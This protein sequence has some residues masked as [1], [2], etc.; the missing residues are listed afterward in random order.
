[1]LTGN[2]SSIQ[3]LRQHL[4][5]LDVPARRVIAKAYWATGKVGLD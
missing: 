2:A 3:Q 1:V 5:K 4:R